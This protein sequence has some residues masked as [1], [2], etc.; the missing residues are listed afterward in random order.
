MSH[1]LRAGEESSII[2]RKRND[3]F[4]CYQDKFY[5]QTRENARTGPFINKID[6]I[7]DLMVFIE[8]NKSQN[9]TL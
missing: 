3:R 9:E 4:V 6:A 1:S 5:Y 8:L 2:T 7:F